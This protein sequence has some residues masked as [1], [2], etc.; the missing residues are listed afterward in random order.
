MVYGRSGTKNVETC[1][2]ERISY[3]L[4][5]TEVIKL[6]KWAVIIEDHYERPMDIEWAKDAET[7][8]LYIVQVRP[9]TAVSQK[10]SGAFC[11]FSL[12]QKG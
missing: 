12:T 6:A 9:E 11:T 5:D 7:N 4:S 8:E 1:L 2:D 3:S 10:E